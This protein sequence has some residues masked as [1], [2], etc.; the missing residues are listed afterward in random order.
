MLYIILQATYTTHAIYG[1]MEYVLHDVYHVIG[2]RYDTHAIYHIT[3][4][5]SVSKDD[6]PTFI[7][8]A[9]LLW[10]LS[11]CDSSHLAD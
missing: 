8:A 7:N 3:G 10:I 2:Y 6:S 9:K 11:V 5:L 4:Y 1:I